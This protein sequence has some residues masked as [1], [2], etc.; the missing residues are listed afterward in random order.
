MTEQEKMGHELAL[1]TYYQQIHLS[2][3]TNK[4]SYAI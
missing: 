1:I 2:V 3:I 4:I